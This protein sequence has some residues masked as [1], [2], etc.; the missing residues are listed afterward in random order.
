MMKAV[1]RGSCRAETLSTSHERK[2]SVRCPAEI[3]GGRVRANRPILTGTSRILQEF[4]ISNLRL[5][6]PH[7]AFDILMPAPSSLT[8]LRDVKD[9]TDRLTGRSRFRL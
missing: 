7:S 2:P 6:I 8:L 4:Q 9:G 5:P 3:P 1:G